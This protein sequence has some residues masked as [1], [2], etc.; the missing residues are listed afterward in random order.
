MTALQRRVDASRKA[1][2]VRKRIWSVQASRIGKLE[3]CLAWIEA[4]DPALVRY[5]RHK[6]GLTTEHA[7]KGNGG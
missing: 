3:A 4:H 1:A 2:R 5:A 7:G 6:F